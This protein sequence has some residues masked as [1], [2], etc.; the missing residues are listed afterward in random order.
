M[1]RDAPGLSLTQA[2]YECLRADLLACRL[3]PGERLKIGELCG[4]LSVSLGAVRE[5]LSRLT[6]EGL[7]VAEPQRGFRVAPVSVAELRDLT[8][9]RIEI[10]GTCL[11]RAVAAGDVAWE[12]GL[13]A[14]HHRLSR[15]PEREPGDARRLS[16]AWAEAHA[17]F[18]RALVAGCDS[19]WLLRLREILYAQSERYRRLSVPLAPAG[20]DLEGEH[21]GIMEAAL[22]R[23]A[24]RA[25]ALLAAHLEVTTAILLKAEAGERREMSPGP[26]EPEAQWRHFVPNPHT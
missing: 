23:D 11:T 12:A 2:A 20:R 5:A 7:V 15:T 8:A 1:P 13:V 26:A 19:R 14:A 10:E 16:E 17:S 24:E 6:S 4:A 9:V 3:R 22:A 21:R 25:V 18:H